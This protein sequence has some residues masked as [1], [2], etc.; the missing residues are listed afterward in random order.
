MRPSFLSDARD[1]FSPE[2]RRAVLNVGPGVAGALLLHGIVALLIFLFMAE[3]AAQHLQ[4]PVHFVPIDLVRLGAETASPDEP[5]KSI[6]PQQRAARAVEAASP[7]PET[8]APGKIKPAPL[9]DLDSKLRALARL[10]QP[11]T[12]LKIDNAQGVSNI[13][14][15]DGAPG[16]QATYSVRDYIRSVV[17]RR[18]YFDLAKLGGRKFNI[19]IRVAMKRD[20]TIVSAEI[21]ERHDALY[22][23][24]AIG[25]RNAVLLSSPIALPPGDYPPTMHF[26]L[27]LDPRDTQR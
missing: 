14:A 7:T 5:V 1:W 26:T 25:A 2:Q 8:T 23:D 12:D 21:V 4:S 11:P 13:A 10:R 27:D 20:G 3:R 6:V 15:A 17:L 24:I 16:D 19:P 18:W 9:D 22:R